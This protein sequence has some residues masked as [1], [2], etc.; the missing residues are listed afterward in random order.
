MD[1]GARSTG[2]E[3]RTT[4]GFTTYIQ[5]THN[6]GQKLKHNPRFDS[7]WRCQAWNTV[8]LQQCWLAASM[9]DTTWQL[10]R[11]PGMAVMATSFLWDGFTWRD[12]FSHATPY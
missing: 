2:Y 6:L 1:G 4:A 12:I 8:S 3:R 9:R 10:P 7:N 5:Q 11:R